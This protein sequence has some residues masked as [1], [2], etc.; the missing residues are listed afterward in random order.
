MIPEGLPRADEVR[1][2]GRVALVSVFITYA[3]AILF[4]LVPSLQA[5]RTDAAAAL[6]AS[7]DR[8]STAG[9]SRARTRAALVVGEVALTLVLMVAAGLLAN[10]F[11]RL[12]RVDPGFAATT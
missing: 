7:G 8:A 4:G 1:L 3:S 6:R 12:Q 10:S 5:S 2:D 11:I 9:R